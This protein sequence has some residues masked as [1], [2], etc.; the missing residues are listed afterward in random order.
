MNDAA[1]TGAR[2]FRLP[3][4]GGLGASVGIVFI[5]LVAFWVMMMI[6]LPTSYMVEYSFRFDL[7]PGKVG[8]P[9]DVHTLDNYRFL[10]FGPE[11]S[12]ERL[13]LFGHEFKANTLHLNVFFKTIIAAILVTMI[14]LAICY[15]I[16]FFMA[17]RAT[18]GMARLMVLCLILPFWVNEILRAFAFRILL[19]TGGVLN[20]FLMDLG[21]IAEPF[22]FIRQ[23][24][25]LYVGLSYAYI[26]LMI[27]PLY[28]ALES[29]D[30]NQIEAARDLG[31]PVW[32]IH[33][34]IVIPHA[35]AGIASGCTM[36]FMLAVGALAMPQILGGPSNLW[37]TQVIYDR[38]NTSLNWPVGAAYAFV[39]LV[40]CIIF[41]LVVM[42]LFRVNLGEIAK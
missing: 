29:L 40:T 36:V 37:F 42:R 6:L 19:G 32:R 33:W 10:L 39:L 1:P 21:V 34:R 2:R 30:R 13:W 12:P 14:D 8:G 5:I 3:T 17:Q 27:F 25:A 23:D 20:T 4:F 18:G 15:P 11:G 16:T 41:V 24:I 31:A 28:N 22:D 38:F 35:K 7:P 9:E 26:L